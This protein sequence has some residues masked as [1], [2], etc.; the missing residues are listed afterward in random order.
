[1]ALA[2]TISSALS[3]ALNETVTLNLRRTKAADSATM[4]RA[5]SSLTSSGMSLA[6]AIESVGL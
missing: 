2:G 5:I 3:E 1:M 6:D 4:A